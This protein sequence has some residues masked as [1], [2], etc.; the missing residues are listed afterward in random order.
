MQKMST[1]NNQFTDLAVPIPLR[2]AEVNGGK[3]VDNTTDTIVYVKGQALDK[4]DSSLSYI[5]CPTKERI[6]LND[7]NYSN[8]S[9]SISRFVFPPSLKEGTYKLCLESKDYGKHEKEFVVSPFWEPKITRIDLLTGLC[10]GIIEDPISRKFTC[11]WF[12]FDKKADFEE[13]KAKNLNAKELVGKMVDTIMDVRGSLILQPKVYPEVKN[14]YGTGKYLGLAVMESETKI[15]QWVGNDLI[16]KMELKITKVDSPVNSGQ[17]MKITIEGV[18]LSSVN[19]TLG[20]ITSPDSRHISLESGTKNAFDFANYQCIY[21]SRATIILSSVWPEGRYLLRLENDMGDS[22]TTEFQI[23]SLNWH[24]HISQLDIPLKAATGLIV[25]TFKR[26]YDY[27][28]FLFTNQKAAEDSKLLP[29]DAIPPT[30]GKIIGKGTAESQRIIG[31]SSRLIENPGF[32]GAWIG[33]GA[34]QIGT[35]SWK[36]DCLEIKDD[37]KTAEEP[38]KIRRKS[39]KMIKR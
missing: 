7:I 23:N 33:F 13:A 34:S 38:D 36:W 19:K 12:L 5:E 24:P 28:W 9:V 1:T 37:T 30:N 17:S 29:P 27:V 39:R 14:A 20:G 3:P 8:V 35:S 10:E 26:K 6:S 15:W 18:G 2:I 22:A 32:T 4:V 25:D 21:D 31:L 16:Q 11:V